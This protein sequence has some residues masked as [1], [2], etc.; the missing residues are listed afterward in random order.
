MDIG[1]CLVTTDGEIKKV[2]IPD[3]LLVELIRK[4]RT[5][6]KEF[7]HFKNESIEIEG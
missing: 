4:F 5:K 3:K 6:G 7:V 1:C 2:V